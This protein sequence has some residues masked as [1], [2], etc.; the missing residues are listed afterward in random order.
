MNTDTYRAIA[1]HKRQV[2]DLMIEFIGPLCNWLQQ[3]RNHYQIQCHLLPAQLDSTIT[4]LWLTMTLHCKVKF[5][6][7]IRPTASQPVCLGIKH[8]SGA[9]DQIFIIVRQLRVC[10]Y[11]AF[12]LTRGLVCRL[13]FLLVFASAVI[14]GSEFRGTRDHILH[15]QIRDFPFRRLLRLSGLR[16]KYSTPLLVASHC[17]AYNISA[18]T[19]Q[20]TVFPVLLAWT[21]SK[22]R[23][24]RI[25]PVFTSPLPIVGRPSIVACTYVAGSFPSRCLK[26]LWANP[27]QFVRD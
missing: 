9:Y 23:L 11:G 2:L 12:S 10:L 25:L 13:L 16:W 8:P 4:R 27:S 3:F 21:A 20:K 15:S 5:K 7:I 26:M 17:R 22:T 24:P 19:V 18:R 6:V 1:W 14:F